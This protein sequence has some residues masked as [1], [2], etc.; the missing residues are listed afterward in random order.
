MTVEATESM[1]DFKEDQ[2]VNLQTLE[3]IFEKT[4]TPRRQEVQ[5]TAS[6]VRVPTRRLPPVVSIHVNVGVSQHLVRRPAAPDDDTQDSTA[7]F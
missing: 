1:H 5:V 3:S 2:R 7:S 4:T 6:F